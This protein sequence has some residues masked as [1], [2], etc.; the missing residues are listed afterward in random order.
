MQ[1]YNP[2]AAASAIDCRQAAKYQKKALKKPEKYD[3]ALSVFSPARYLGSVSEGYQSSLRNYIDDNPDQ[4]ILGPDEEPRHRKLPKEAAFEALMHLKYLHSLIEPGE[5][6]GLLAAQ[7]IGEPSTQMTLNTFHFAGHG[8]KNVTL[9]IPRLREIIMTASDKPKTPQMTI[10][11]KKNITK[12][13]AQ[14][15]CSQ[16]S[17]LTLDMIM[18]GADV[19]ERFLPKRPG[20]EQ[21]IRSYTITLRFIPR[22][23]YAEEYELTSDQLQ[24]TLTRVFVKRLVSTIKQEMKGSRSRGKE[25][26]NAIGQGA[27]TS[28]FKESLDATT[29]DEESDDR[30]TRKRGKKDTAGSGDEDED[31][32]GGDGDAT[33][34]RSRMR[35]TQQSTYDE[36]EDED[37]EHSVVVDD[38]SVIDNNDVGENEN[39]SQYRDDIVNNNQFIREYR[40]DQKDGAWCEFELH[41]SGTLKD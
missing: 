15:L 33:S 38:A 31:D 29:T 32:D 18:Q 19:T 23:E 3:P 22:D 13:Q 27:D 1:K 30:T 37:D 26:E 5:A 20:D 4:V 39:D 12:Q 6:V 36:S 9:G 11:F 10:P 21:R 40:F 8:A 28:N 41:V 25:E 2:Q 34:A 7:S 17:R 16:M 14:R 24:S 35:R